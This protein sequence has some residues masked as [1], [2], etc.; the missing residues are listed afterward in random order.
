V[1]DNYWRAHDDVP[2]HCQH[3]RITRMFLLDRVR[4]KLVR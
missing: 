2:E 1:M 3:D 4:A